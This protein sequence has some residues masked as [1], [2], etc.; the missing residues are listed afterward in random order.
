MRS[1][2]SIIAQNFL[3]FFLVFG[4]IAS[5]FFS[6]S[7]DLKDIERIKLNEQPNI[8]QA[9]N[10]EILYSDSAIVR[11]RILAEEMRNIV[12]AKEP[13]REFP[14]GVLVDFFN[15]NQGKSSQL[16]ANYAEYMEKKKE[17][18]LRDSV[19]I[20][21]F[22]NEQLET[23]EL[24]WKER[25]NKIFSKKFVRIT[26]PTEIIEG[27]GFSSDMEFTNWEIDSVSGI[28]ESKTFIGVED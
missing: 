4:L 5:L 13:K 17:I 24:I 16:S 22:R 9:K 15:E 21:N 27:Y 25:S 19:V 7:N 14:K 10:V 12:D 26:T 28:F 1:Q 8:E 20:W 2:N 6:C 18:I 23:E 3:P 11:M